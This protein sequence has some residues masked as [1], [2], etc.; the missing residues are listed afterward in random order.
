MLQ[1]YPKLYRAALER[2]SMYMLFIHNHTCESSTGIVLLPRVEARR[3]RVAPRG[4]AVEKLTIARLFSTLG[5]LDF[6]NRAF[7][8]F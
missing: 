8:L 1:P 2:K 7:G 4:T 6:G 5:T 3:P